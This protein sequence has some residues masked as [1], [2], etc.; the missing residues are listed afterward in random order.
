MLEFK[1]T[2]IHQ[3]L[4]SLEKDWSIPELFT[5]YEPLVGEPLAV[6]L[7]AMQQMVYVAEEH[8]GELSE[9]GQLRYHFWKQLRTSRIEERRYKYSVK[10][11]DTYHWELTVN[12]EGLFYKDLNPMYDQMAGQ[13][14]EQLFSDFWFYGPL[15]PMPNLDDRKWVVSQIRNAFLQIGPVS[16]KHFELFEYPKLPIDHFWEEGDHN[17]KDFVNMRYFGLESGRTNWHDG[18]VYLGFIAFERLLADPQGLERVITPAIR[19]EV[20]EHLKAK[21]GKPSREPEDPEKARMKE[22]YMSNGGMELYIHRDYGDTYSANPADELIW[23][24]ELLDDLSQRLKTIDDYAGLSHI[25]T[26]MRHH[27]VPDIEEQFLAAAKQPNLKARQAIGQ[28]LSE[29]RYDEAAAQVTLSL[30]EFEHESDYWRN[31][32]FSALG[33]MRENK[34]VQ[35]FVIQCLKGDDETRFKKGVEVLISWGMKGDTALMDRDL[36]LSLNWQDACAADPHFNH[37]LGKA[38]KIIESK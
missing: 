3:T 27:R 17:A 37:A 13:V 6:R 16:Q 15:M 11:S 34:A 26:V 32:V 22:V 19:A 28:V 12:S 24:R 31:Y 25:A 23:K 38:I 5:C 1:G 29:Q 8:Y 4:G 20:M 21:D 33:N 14:H 30:L 9:A 7:Y 35:H 18:L 36:W 10:I 2:Y